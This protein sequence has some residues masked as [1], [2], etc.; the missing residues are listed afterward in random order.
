MSVS[1]PRFSKAVIEALDAAKI[2]G[3]RA[4]VEPH[5][6]LGVW[7][8]VVSSRVFIRS[9]N[10]KP[11]GWREAFREDARGTLQIPSGRE[12]RINARPA[13]GDRLMEAIED[14]Y[15]AKYP[16]P[17]SRKYVVGFRRPK[18]RATTVELIPR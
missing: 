6:F 17:G 4:G 14:A 15:A 18:R 7:V 2:I 16:T 10:D 1:A 12:L 9:W 11:T 5:R 3:I 13:R 8:V